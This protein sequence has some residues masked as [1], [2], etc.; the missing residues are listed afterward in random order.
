MSRHIVIDARHWRDF[1]IGT[2]VRNLARGL[3]R[4]DPDSRYTLIARPEDA[5]DLSGLGPNFSTDVYER[6]DVGLRHNVMFPHFLRSFHAD[7]FHIPL[8]SVAYWMPRPYVVTIHDMSSLLY[9]A[10]SDV[11]ETLHEE[12]YRRGALRAPDSFHTSSSVQT[13]SGAALRSPPCPQEAG[14]RRSVM[15][16]S[17]TTWP[18]ASAKPVTC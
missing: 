7:L 9:P 13:I 2:Y 6:P 1:G 4:F 10:R 15:F 18:V 16:R 8:N 5:A 14:G 17:I 12:R 3:A 11:R